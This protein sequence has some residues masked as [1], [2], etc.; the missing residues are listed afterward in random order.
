MAMLRKR[1][2]LLKQYRFF[3]VLFMFTISLC[4]T[5]HVC[6]CL[7]VNLL[8]FFSI[9]LCSLPIA[10]SSPMH[11]NGCLCQ[12]VRPSI[13]ASCAVCTVV[14]LS[15]GLDTNTC[16][17]ATQFRLLW[18]HN[19]STRIGEKSQAPRNRYSGTHEK[20]SNRGNNN[21]PIKIIP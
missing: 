10:N 8:K 3:A 4:M 15:N 16:M 13:L 11:G 9:F 17:H 18:L 19:M 7:C 1:A 12:T 20:H 5:L 6:T 2:G 21:T 14:P